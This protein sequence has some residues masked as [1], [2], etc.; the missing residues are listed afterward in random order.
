MVRHTDHLP[1]RLL[2]LHGSGSPL[3]RGRRGGLQSHVGHRHQI[4]GHL[5]ARGEV[6][7]EPPLLN[8]DRTERVG[9]HRLI[10]LLGR[11]PGPR[12]TD[13]DW[14]ISRKALP[15][16]RSRRLPGCLVNT[17]IGEWS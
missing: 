7:C 5:A 16:F 14:G 9:V 10:A 8:G 1:R 2:E 11:L 4:L 3:R 15:L 12:A 17:L 13:R 6:G